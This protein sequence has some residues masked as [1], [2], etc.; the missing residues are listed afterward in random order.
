MSKFCEELLK[1]GAKEKI[2]EIRELTQESKLEHSLTICE[3]LD[4]SN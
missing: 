1:F 3:E 4:K 2:E